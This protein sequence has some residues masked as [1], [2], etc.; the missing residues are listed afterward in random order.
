MGP[1]QNLSAI[2]EIHSFDDLKEFIQ[3]ETAK[4]KVARKLCLTRKLDQA[5]W[6]L[7][8]KDLVSNFNKKLPNKSVKA[9]R[10]RL[11]ESLK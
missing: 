5:S 11:K 7:L 10:K 2:A 8:K 3:K 6:K 1:E 4:R 9:A